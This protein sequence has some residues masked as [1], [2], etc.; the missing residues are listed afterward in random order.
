MTTVVVR[1]SMKAEK[2]DVPPLYP[3]DRE[4]HAPT[5]N[6]ILEPFE[7]IRRHDLMD[8]ENLYKCFE[9]KLTPLQEELL[10][11][12]EV[13]RGLYGLAAVGMDS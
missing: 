1:A 3:E 4:C 11:L 6:R 12:L 8:G 9:P 5:A 10:R 2:L 13:P 7:D